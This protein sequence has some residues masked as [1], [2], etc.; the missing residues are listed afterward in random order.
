M[1]YTC[2]ILSWISIEKVHRVIKFNQEG[3]LK[4]YTDMNTELRKNRKKDF[5]KDSF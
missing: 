4:T 2:G 3:W 5:E 1:L